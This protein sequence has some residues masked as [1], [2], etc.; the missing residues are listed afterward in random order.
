MKKSIEYETPKIEFTKFELGMNIMQDENESFDGDDVNFY[1][2]DP[3]ETV[4]DVPLP[5]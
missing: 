2:S 4:E 1:G 3:D 5:W